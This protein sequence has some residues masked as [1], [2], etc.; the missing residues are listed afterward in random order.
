M[1]HN[2]LRSTLDT[3]K[4]WIANFFAL[5]TQ[6]KSFQDNPIIGSPRLNR[7]GL[8]IL[9]VILAHGIFRLRQAF[10]LFLISTD[11]R[12]AFHRDGFLLV[13]NVLPPK[14]FK[15]LQQSFE[16]PAVK[17][18]S[19]RQGDTLTH[20]QLLS[21]QL[22]SQI[23]TIQS[24]LR[25]PALLNRL[26]YASGMLLSPW[27]YFLRIENHL[28]NPAAQQ[29]STGLQKIPN[30]P[31]KMAH[32]DA[33]HPT[34]KAWLFLHDVS[35]EQGPFCYYPASHKLTVK[36]LRWEYQQSLIASKTDNRY[37]ARGSFRLDDSGRKNLTP[38]QP[39]SFTVPANSLIIANTFGFHFRG[40]A[41]QGSTRDALWASSWRAPFLPLPLPDSQKL[42]AFFYKKMQQHL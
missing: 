7:L 40:N 9:R 29:P 26:R 1:D 13:T 4:Q 34:M 33:F 28:K 10:L 24:I 23:T 15:Q 12:R 14:E 42:R 36:R 16:H 18:H 3:G 17:L 5:F 41:A 8:H 27:F 39:K 21:P 2:A 32:A 37:T 19:S 22:Q 30:D 25:Q 38:H 20:S 6:A 31:Q 35:A 11:E